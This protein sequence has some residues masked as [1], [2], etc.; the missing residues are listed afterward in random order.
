MV[1]EKNVIRHR[2]QF[3][4]AQFFRLTIL[5]IMILLGVGFS[6]NWMILSGP[7]MKNMLYQM[8]EFG[9]IS[10]G[11]MLTRISGRIDLSVVGTA[12][13]SAIMATL[14][15]QHNYG[16]S[17]GG[18]WVWVGI[19]IAF[20]IALLCGSVCGAFNAFLIYKMKFPA[21]VATI[22]TGTLYSGIGLIMTKGTTIGGLPSAYQKLISM[23]FG[24]I[25]LVIVV[26]LLCVVLMAFLLYKTRF[27][28]NLYL[29][30]TSMFATKYAGINEMAIIFKPYIIAGCMSAL[31][32]MI[33]LGR[34]NSVNVSN[35]NSYALMGVLICM[36]GGIN[37]SGGQG[38]VENVVMATITI[39]L[40]NS[41]L[42]LYHNINTFYNNII[43][44]GLLIFFMIINYY[45]DM[46]QEHQLNKKVNEKIES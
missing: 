28:L 23:R 35:G 44:G 25:P 43:L 15:L 18:T 4:D 40:I 29:S 5:F 22:G 36:I 33:M 20:V 26:Y 6:K 37:P 30:G 46:R 16:N 19:F 21:F 39:Q 13:F 14:Y 45:V 31:G 34:F 17:E 38:R 10:L 11:I 2:I 42:S 1:K 41:S 8:P 7:M 12:N 3:G 27:G 9:L 24:Y 32:G